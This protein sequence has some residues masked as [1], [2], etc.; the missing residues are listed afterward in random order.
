MCG[1]M[2]ILVLRH[3]AG[4]SASQ[5]LSIKGAE[6]HFPGEKVMGQ[7]DV[8]T[9]SRRHLAIPPCGIAATASH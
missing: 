9:A 1:S 5:R 8:E 3:C 4:A 2:R 6:T 7:F